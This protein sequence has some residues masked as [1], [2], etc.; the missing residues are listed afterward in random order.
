MI[1]KE[2]K[3]SGSIP[4]SIYYKYFMLGVK[5]NSILVFIFLIMI[6]SQTIYFGIHYWTFLWFKS[7]IYDKT[8]IYIGFG[9]VLALLLVFSIFRFGLVLFYQ[10]KANERI[11]NESLKGII[12][13]T[14]IFFDKNPTGRIINYFTK[15]IIN[16]D[17]ALV[18]NLNE[19]CHTFFLLAGSIIVGFT[20]VPWSL[21]C[22]AIFIPFLIFIFKVL[23]PVLQELRRMEI[24]TRSPLMNSLNN[25]LGGSAIIRSF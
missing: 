6:I 16:L 19:L 21:S 20:L 1:D 7:S 2:E 9:T 23:A 24:L 14:S 22:M 11:H 13:T 18:L 4:Y 3:A 8:F 25:I 15:D 12:E 17:E 10:I 5:R